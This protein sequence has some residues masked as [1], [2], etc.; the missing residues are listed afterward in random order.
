MC[1][2]GGNLYSIQLITEF[3][4]RSVHRRNLLIQNQQ[5]TMFHFIELTAGI[6]RVVNGLQQ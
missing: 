5:P 6:L 1:A 4:Q 2:S 3:K